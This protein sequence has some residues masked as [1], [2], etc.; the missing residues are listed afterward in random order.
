MIYWPQTVLTPKTIMFSFWVQLSII[1]DILSL[2]RKYQGL[3]GGGSSSPW[4]AP[5][6]CWPSDTWTGSEVA[7]CA[8]TGCRQEPSSWNQRQANPWRCR[9][10][11]RHPWPLR[12]P[13]EHTAQFIWSVCVCMHT[14][15]PHHWAAGSLWL[16]WYMQTL[17]N[18]FLFCQKEQIKVVPPVWDVLRLFPKFSSDP[19][20]FCSCQKLARDMPIRHCRETTHTHLWEQVLTNKTCHKL[21]PSNDSVTHTHM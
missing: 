7:L 21:A 2:C 13:W 19:Y 4:G 12:W 9:R 18:S 15:L 5:R 3:G 11:W 10:R 14:Q 20:L 8:P 6:A 17:Y 16:Y 1:L